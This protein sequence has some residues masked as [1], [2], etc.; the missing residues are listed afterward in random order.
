MK[1]DLKQLPKALATRK[2]SRD[3]YAR[4][5]VVEITS[6]VQ[7]RSGL[8][9]R[10]KKNEDN[11]RNINS[12]GVELVPGAVPAAIP[13]VQP[14]LD[15]IN[16][17]VYQNLISVEPW[18]QV[19][20]EM[21]DG[22]VGDAVERDLQF[23]MQRANFPQKLWSALKITSCT[24]CAM[25]RL[26]YVNTVGFEIDVVHPGDAMIYPSSA[27]HPSKAKSFGHR[28]W[29]T[30]SQAEAKMNAGEWIKC[31]L[32]GSDDPQQYD[33][34]R[35]KQHSKVESGGNSSP[36]DESLEFWEIVRKEDLGDG[37]M[38]YK[39]VIALRS[40]VLLD[41]KPFG[42]TM[43]VGEQAQFI[44]YS[45]PDYYDLRY[46]DEYGIFWPSGSPAQ[47]L[48]GIQNFYNDAF[49]IWYWGHVASAFPAVVI[50]GGS[51]GK[52]LEKLVPGAILENPSA[53][54]AQVVGVQFNGQSF[55][56]IIAKLEDI[57]QKAVRVN[58][59]AV[60]QQLTSHTTEDEVQELAA[61]QRQSDDQYIAYICL[62]LSKFFTYAYELY[63]IHHDDI[64]NT[65][66]P[67]IEVR[68]AAILES[69]RFNFQMN[70]ARSSNSPQALIQKLQM[71]LGL[72][73]R[74]GAQFDL[75]K[76]EQAVVR[77]LQLPFSIAKIQISP[78]QAAQSMMMAA[79]G[80]QM[81]QGTEQA[82]GSLDP[83]TM[84]QIMQQLNPESLAA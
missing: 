62:G 39:C 26:R 10:W 33:V 29:M 17:T 22:G 74:P 25:L 82:L 40:Q 45:G 75:L 76:V 72:A 4:E 36:K 3:D 41:C 64:L 30:I 2:D 51:L 47:N 65:F 31:D 34:G 9:D 5:C 59:M 53:I 42:A 60:G 63:R 14:M 50:S 7:S 24:N 70:G 71:I 21:D 44:P 54:Q 43:Q 55:P 6:G 15:R 32:S 20:P 80:G 68:D 83:V 84:Q 37:L 57:A 61:M 23:L 28:F 38:W 52:K 18:V 66:G 35:N 16:G 49:N 13:L 77:A 27:Q 69:K 67:S 79:Q 8:A 1:Y 48:Q 12:T 58:Q 73:A 81:D 78:E 46:D 56:M 11:Y 19:T